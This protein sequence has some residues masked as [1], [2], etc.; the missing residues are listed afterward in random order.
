MDS[1]EYATLATFVGQKNEPFVVWR[2]A[3]SGPEEFAI[4]ALYPVLAQAGR[5]G[6]EL[7]ST[8]TSAFS[9][10]TLYFRRRVSD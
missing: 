3:T 2:E 5:D 9:G 4:E 8:N 6:W 10:E 7:V 1:W